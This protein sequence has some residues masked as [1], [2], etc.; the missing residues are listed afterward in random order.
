MQG[1]DITMDFEL[2]NVSHTPVDSVKLQFFLN[3]SDTPFFTPAVNL[4]GDSSSSVS[5]VIPTSALLFDNPVLVFATVPTQEFFT[6]NNITNSSFYVSRDSLKPNFNI[7]FDGKDI[8]DGDIISS[9][10]EVVITLEDN[11]PLPL[12]TTFSLSFTIIFH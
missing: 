4:A 9:K 6:Y 12:D 3:N 11:S 2:S 10:P 1:F 8:I 7:T 5:Y